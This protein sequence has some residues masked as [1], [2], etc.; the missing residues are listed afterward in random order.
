[1]LLNQVG[2]LG[3]SQETSPKCSQLK[4]MTNKQL[5]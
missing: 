2:F 3:K 5:E 4:T 1:L